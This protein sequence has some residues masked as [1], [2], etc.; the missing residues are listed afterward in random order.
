MK[1]ATILFLLGLLVVSVA[2]A[3]NTTPAPGQTPVN[4]TPA[5]LGG[6]TSTE[7]PFLVLPTLTPY[8]LNDPDLLKF[9]AQLKAALDTNDPTALRDTISFSKWTG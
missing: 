9:E 6:P 4:Q 5:F 8:P 3:T 1:Q 2:C 7:I